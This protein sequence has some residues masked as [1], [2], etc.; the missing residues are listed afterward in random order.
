LRCDR[1][2]KYEGET[3]RQ[4]V[5]VHFFQ[6]QRGTRSLNFF[7]PCLNF[8]GRGTTEGTGSLA[9]ELGVN[10]TQCD[11]F[12]TNHTRLIANELKEVTNFCR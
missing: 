1:K 12:V 2:G 4:R 6:G 3:G 8:S 11:C 9:A 10:K 7:G 5:G